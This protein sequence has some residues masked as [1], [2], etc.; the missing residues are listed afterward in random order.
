MKIDISLEGL[1]LLLEQFKR[2]SQSQE[3]LEMENR[4]LKVAE[5]LAHKIR[6]NVPKGET[7]NLEKSVVAKK[8][9][10]KI[11]GAPAAFVAIDRK[12]APHAHLVEYGTKGIRMAKKT[13]LRFFVGGQVIFAKFVGAMPAQ[14]FFRQTVDNEEI[15]IVSQIAQETIEAIERAA[16]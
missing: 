16:K 14:P 11:K 2:I 7:R 10:N 13:A 8:F 12:V 3:G 1:P 4:L 6:S 5:G 15:K 9:K